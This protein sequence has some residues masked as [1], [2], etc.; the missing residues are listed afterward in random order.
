MLPVLFRDSTDTAT[1]DGFG[2]FWLE[3][4]PVGTFSLTISAGGK[5]VTIDDI[6]T[7]KDVNLGDIAL[8]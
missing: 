3:D 2:D 8:S 7:E 1:T 5:T 6:S 4:L